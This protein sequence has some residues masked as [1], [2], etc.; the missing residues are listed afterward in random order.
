MLI[1]EQLSQDVAFAS[2]NG[3]RASHFQFLSFSAEL[4]VSIY[5]TEKNDSVRID[6]NRD[7]WCLFGIAV[8]NLTLQSARSEIYS[9]VQYKRKTVLST[10]NVNLLVSSMR[11]A[12]FRFALCNSDLC[13]VDGRPLLRIA[14]WLGLPL[15]ELVAGSS[16]T[17][18]LL[19]K[20]EKKT[21]SIFLLGGRGAIPQ[22]AMKRINSKRGGLYAVGALDPGSGTVEELSC[23]NVLMEIN[24][25]HPDI[26][27]V[28]L[29]AFKG[30]KWIGH[31]L[32]RLDAT[33]ISYLGATINFLAGTVRRAPL[34]IQHMGLEWCWR[35]IQE[36][37]LF[38]R[39]LS[40]GLTLLKFLAVKFVRYGSTYR[41]LKKKYQV[42][43]PDLDVQ[44]ERREDELTLH[45]GRNLCFNDHC[46]A[47]EVFISTVMKQKSIIL[48]FQKTE[49][50]DSVFMALLLLL[51]KHQRRNN[52]QVKVTHVSQQFENLI[53]LY[54]IDMSF[55]ALGVVF[56]NEQG[57]IK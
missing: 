26:L 36:P 41:R 4:S 54:N 57:K 9:R 24:K 25:S 49:Y 18:E 53:S 11:N 45:F 48:D 10:L 39:Y 43:P 1:S 6:F 19:E 30:T 56:L 46:A 12:E 55:S 22:Q 29:G 40:D 20:K 21:L 13:T 35:I 2:R 42:Q 23:E 7:V 38:S 31:N 17:Q 32:G 33:V 8:D 34:I 44:V 51:C 47:R 50:A 15:Q 5:L 16:L 27:L 28:A 52:K 3:H 14:R 37:Q